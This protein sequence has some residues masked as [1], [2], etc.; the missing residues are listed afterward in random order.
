MLKAKGISTL[1]SGGTGK[2]EAIT[3]DGGASTRYLGSNMD[4]VSEE[5]A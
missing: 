2:R 4:V 5:P 1:N 3:S